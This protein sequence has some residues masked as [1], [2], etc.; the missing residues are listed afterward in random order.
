MG[1]SFLI[2]IFLPFIMSMQSKRLELHYKKKKGRHWLNINCSDIVINTTELNATQLPNERKFTELR[3]NY[4]FFFFLLKIFAILGHL[5]QVCRFAQCT[6]WEIHSFKTK[7][8]H[9]H[10]ATQILTKVSKILKSVTLLFWCSK[11]CT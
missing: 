9:L 10:S 1:L 11:K 3:F 6:G 8:L 7:T 4:P 5:I 2:L